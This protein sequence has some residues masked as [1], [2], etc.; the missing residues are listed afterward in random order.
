MY[1][2]VN[3]AIEDLARRH[4]D[5]VW[6]SIKEKA[7]VEE[8]FISMAGYPDEL[9]YQL[10]AAMSDVLHQ[11]VDEVLEALGEHWVLYTATEGY[12]HL[13][14]IAGTNLW[15]FLANLDTLHAHVAMSFPD[16]RPPSFRCS[17]TTARSL[18]L[19]YYSHRSGLAPFVVGLVKGLGRRFETPVRVDVARARD[20]DGGDHDVF[21]V[22]LESQ[23]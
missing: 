2:L 23:E 7:G 1:G 11:P 12:S 6:L 18:R 8:E 10:I 19:H 22:E 21:M 9:T 20:D 5:D 4:G 14:P 3:S 15:E 16:L 13:L 17:D